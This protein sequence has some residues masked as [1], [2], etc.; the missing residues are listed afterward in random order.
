MHFASLI[1]KDEKDKLVQILRSQ[2]DMVAANLNKTDSKLLFIIISNC[3]HSGAVICAAAICLNNPGL[4]PLYAAAESLCPKLFLKF[5][6][7]VNVMVA[8]VETDVVELLPLAFAFCSISLSSNYFY[9]PL[10]CLLCCCHFRFIFHV[11]APEGGF[12]GI[13]NN[14]Q[15][16]CYTYYKGYCCYTRFLTN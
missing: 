5:G 2:L 15:V 14:F 13:K 12:S 1:A 8:R 10:H 9:K 16:G 3:I 7:P 4:F 6:I 11:V